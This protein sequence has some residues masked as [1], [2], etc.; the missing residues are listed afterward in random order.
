MRRF[1]IAASL[2]ALVGLAVIFITPAA[3][4]AFHQDPAGVSAATTCG[5]KNCPTSTHCCYS[6]TGK[7]ICV[8]NGVPCPECAPPK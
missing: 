3:T 2:L 8:R 4:G 1:L 6:C 5:S 7:P